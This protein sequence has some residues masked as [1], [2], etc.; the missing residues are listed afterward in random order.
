MGSA[1]D[2]SPDAS[3]ASGNSARLI[4]TLMRQEFCPLAWQGMKQK[5]LLRDCMESGAKQLSSTEE[6]LIVR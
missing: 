5:G 3:Q 1:R 4:L 6:T 2:S